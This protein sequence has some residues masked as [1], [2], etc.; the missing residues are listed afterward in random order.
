MID[1]LAYGG[2]VIS[3]KKIVMT[4]ISY[5]R[6]SHIHIQRMLPL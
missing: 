4:S 2:S 6:H 1:N 3:K 5:K